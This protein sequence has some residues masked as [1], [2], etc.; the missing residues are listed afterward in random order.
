MKICYNGHRL[1]TRSN[2]L[3]SGQQKSKGNTNKPPQQPPKPTKS[4]QSVKV[5]QV[6]HVCALTTWCIAQKPRLSQ[7]LQQLVECHTSNTWVPCGQQ[8]PGRA[9]GVT[10]AKA[11]TLTSRPGS[12]KVEKSC[13]P[14]WRAL[15]YLI[16][17]KQKCL[18]RL[19]PGIPTYM[20]ERSQTEQSSPFQVQ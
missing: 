15:A 5:R 9:Q 11:N 20:S 12:M 3:V 13:V 8:L 6:K 10:K 7:H 18:T 2:R 1:I 14:V 4:D 19:Y 16:Q 17:I